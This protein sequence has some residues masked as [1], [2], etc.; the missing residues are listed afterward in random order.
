M[1]L[2][3]ARSCVWKISADRVHL[4]ADDLLDLAVH[5]PAER[6]ERPEAGAHLPDEAGADEQPVADRLRVGGRVA[7][8]G[9][10]EL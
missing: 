2:R 4:L 6:R 8:R 10:M 1:N 3:P 7:Q 9:E 5:P